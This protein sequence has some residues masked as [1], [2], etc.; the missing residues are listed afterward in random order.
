MLDYLSNVLKRRINEEHMR[1]GVSFVDSNNTYIY[2]NVKIGRDTVI[3]PNVTVM[4]GVVIGNNCVI[5]AN[6]YIGNDVN[7]EDGTDIEFGSK[8]L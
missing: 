7:V 5:K 2:D 8:I 3:Y 4:P 6:S 1:N